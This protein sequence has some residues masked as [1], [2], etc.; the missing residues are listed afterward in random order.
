[1][2]GMLDYEAA[3][4][5]LEQLQAAIAKA[6]DE[7]EDLGRMI[8][9]KAA[10][11]PGEMAAL[12]LAGDD[13][14]ARKLVDANSEISERRHRVMAALE[15]LRRAEAEV[16]QTIEMYELH[17]RRVHEFE[18]AKAALAALAARRDE[19]DARLDMA[20]NTT[21]KRRIVEQYRDV[22]QLAKRT[23]NAR[24]LAAA[25]GEVEDFDTFCGQ[26]GVEV[27]AQN[28]VHAIMGS[29]YVN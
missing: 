14:A 3:K 28:P 25:L 15:G 1:M 23:Y 4:E 12:Y 10:S 2:E 7:V 21:E 16:G 17:E 27:V 26:I 19:F 20:A 9:E 24:R 22:R 8:S 13:K 18:E 6:A 11:F 5:Q 29:R